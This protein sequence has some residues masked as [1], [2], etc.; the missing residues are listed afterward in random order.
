MS[1]VSSYN[2]YVQ[3]LHLL[4]LLN[5]IHFSCIKLAF[6]LN[7]QQ[8]NAAVVLSRHMAGSWWTGVNCLHCS[9]L[10]TTELV[11]CWVYVSWCIDD[12]C[13]S[14]MRCQSVDIASLY[15]QSLLVDIIWCQ[16]SGNTVF[17]QCH[18]CSMISPRTV[19]VICLLPWCSGFSVLKSIYV[20][21]NFAC[22]LLPYLQS[23]VV[24]NTKKD[25]DTVIYQSF[26]QSIIL[27]CSKMN[28]FIFY[29]YMKAY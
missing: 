9:E 26:S 22:K 12:V 1:S 21:D 7:W 29:E 3:K 17:L 11:K 5:C 14:V 15:N 4:V 24:H 20:G 23:R 16:W 13:H 8:L 28:V 18:I 10:N 25:V 6:N 27:H 2:C 19:Q